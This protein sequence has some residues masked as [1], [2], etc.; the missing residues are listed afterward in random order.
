MTKQAQIAWRGRAKSG[1]QVNKEQGA[2]SRL[3][4][5][6]MLALVPFLGSTLA[7]LYEAGFLWFYS[8]PRSFIRVDL[9]F[10]IQASMMVLLAGTLFITI[11]QMSL[12][13]RAQRESQFKR[14]AATSLQYLMVIGALLYAIRPDAWLAWGTALV[15][16]GTLS[17][18]LVYAEAWWKGD[19]KL[20]FRDR[21]DAVLAS[22][23]F[24]DDGQQ[25]TSGWL[26]FSLFLCF[27]L[28]VGVFQQGVFAGKSKT[29][30]WALKTDPTLLFV[31]QYGDY[32]LFKRY[33]RLDGRLMPEV[34]VLKVAEGSPLE[35]VQVQLP[36]GVQGRPMFGATAESSSLPAAAS[37]AASNAASKPSSAPSH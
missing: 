6:V 8:I 18:P 13:W 29:S 12:E 26:A 9:P 35:M 3:S 30:Y 5:G 20:P 16:F 27:L 1:A 32:T 11:L 23:K 2:Q 14:I 25:S 34:H 24:G 17:I 4:E 7:F 37:G 28:C 10:I 22:E 31:E 19:R 15:F 36:K 21:V 33:D